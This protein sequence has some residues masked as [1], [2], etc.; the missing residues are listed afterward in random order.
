MDTFLR[1]E[2]R[3]GITV[4]TLNRAPVNALNPAFLD[5]LGAWLDAAARDDSVR[6]VVLASPFKVFS[7]GLDLA[8]MQGY[9]VTEQTA[10][11]DALNTAFV[12]LYGFPKP[13]VAA[14][15]G[16]AIAGGLFFP[17]SADYSVAA[18]GAKLGLAEVRVGASFPVAP[19]EIARAELT[20]QGLRRLMLSGLPVDAETALGFGA[21]DEIAEGDALL[22]RACRA[23]HGLA[24]APA[25]TYATIKDQIRAA[26]LATIRTA[27][28]EGTDPTRAG[29]FTEE[30]RAAMA[31]AL[32]R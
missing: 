26:T 24:Q 28:D 21:I 11:V 1:T 5:A 27:I 14:V 2:D 31:A 12:A 32:A 13:L 8:E 23:A 29:W 16:A 6:A 17:L 18:P 9:G 4:L 10:I 19:L 7:A 3:D 25:G 30:T 20:P 15:G 22:D